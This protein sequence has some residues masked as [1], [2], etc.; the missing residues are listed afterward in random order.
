[1]NVNNIELKEQKGC[2]FSACSGR[3][4]RL[5]LLQKTMLI[6]AIAGVALCALIGWGVCDALRFSLV[7]RV[8]LISLPGV[9]GG[10]LGSGGAVFLKADKIR[11][12]K[13]LEILQLDPVEN[14]GFY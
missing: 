14:L 7:S 10:V 5:T 6:G 2:L 3:A 4:S 8:C 11:K 1:M 9:L 12:Q 13:N